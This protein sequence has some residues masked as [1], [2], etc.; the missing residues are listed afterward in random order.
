MKFIPYGHQWIDE[1]DIEEVVAVLKS[2]WI[3]TG[4]KIA[5]FEDAL[6]SYIGTKYAVAV[7]SG[8][9][10]LDIAVQTLNLPKGSEVIT[11]PFTFV[12]TSNAVLYNNLKPIFADI[13]K[14]TR[15]IN[16]DEVRKK[17]TDKTKAIIY[18]DYAGQPCDIEEI[19]EIAEDHELYL[20]ED[21]CH[22]IG[23]EYKG[24]KV[25]NFADV[26][27]FSFHPVKHITTG[28]GGAVVTNNKEFYDRLKILRNHGIDKSALDRFGPE[29]GWAYDLK[30]LGRNYRITDFQA[31]LGI[32]QLKKLDEF[33]RR[34][35]RIV[36]MY[37]AAFDAM[38]EIEAPVVLSYV[39]PIWHIYTVL[40][41]GINRDI[42][43]SKMRERNIGVNVHYIPIYRFSYYQEY[44]NFNPKDFP[45]TDEVF[46]KIVTLPL[47]PKMEDEEVIYVVDTV[48]E[49][50]DEIK[51]M[52]AAK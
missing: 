42:F 5:E 44:F 13:E 37:N 14:E 45:V 38:P 17:I 34:R 22:A 35:E 24:K 47:F 25:G 29:A 36:K 52:R 18:V 39:K 19:K 40:L 26:T 21:A 41:N 32:S 16:P 51:K 8:T 7:N 2:D 23:A 6:C 15:N 46:S 30:L 1:S 27:I 11:T 28:E 31:A 43:F 9:S 20:I 49:T 33:V 3:T 50:I 4:P 10:A 12:A 48:K